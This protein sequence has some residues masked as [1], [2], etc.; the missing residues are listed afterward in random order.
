M[1]KIKQ[2]KWFT[3][4]GRQEGLG[5]HGL[6]GRVSLMTFEQTSGR[7]KGGSQWILGVRMVQTEGTTGA[8]ALRPVCPGC[9]G[10]TA[11]RPVCLEQREGGEQLERRSE[12]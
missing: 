11:R 5:S 2:A 4:G 9:G 3:E 7:N 8:K 10:G 12:G 1:K 6:V